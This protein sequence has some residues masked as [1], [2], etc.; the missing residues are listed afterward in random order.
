MQ[1][2]KRNYLH[3]ADS[4]NEWSKKSWFDKTIPKWFNYH[5]FAFYNLKCLY[6]IIN[7]CISFEGV[8]Y[9]IKNKIT[10]TLKLQESF[11]YYHNNY[12]ENF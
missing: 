7:Y 9:F 4:Y 5:K 10:N 11:V 6:F 12:V 2:N 1:M 8:R 3:I